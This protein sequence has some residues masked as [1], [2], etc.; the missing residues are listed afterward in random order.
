[1]KLPFLK[2]WVADWVSDESLRLVSLSAKGLWIEMLC[3]MARSPE[4][5]KLMTASG[6]PMGYAQLARLVASTEAEIT[7][8]V[9]ELGDAGVFSVDRMGVIYS[10]RMVRDEK[11]RKLNRDRVF[12]WRNGDVMPDVMPM[13]CSGNGAEARVN[14]QEAINKRPK[15][16]EWLA[17]A[18]EI[19]WKKSGAESAFDYYESTGWLIGGKAPVQ[20]WKACARN[21]LKRSGET[22]TKKTK[23]PVPQN[24]SAPLYRLAGFN[25]YSEWEKAGCPTPK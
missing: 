4:H 11:E 7:P 17:Y 1:M 18:K 3:I 10:R 21:C 6:Q 8:L 22:E 19:G 16:E 23:A 2:F 14:S 24:Y 9:Q 15:K 5:G 12:R 13:K 25:S 20:D